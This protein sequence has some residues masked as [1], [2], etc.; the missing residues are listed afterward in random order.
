[1]PR[2]NQ[3]PCGYCDGLGLHRWYCRHTVIAYLA[4]LSGGLLVL[5][6]GIATGARQ[7]SYPGLAVW[8]LVLDV[9]IALALLRGRRE[10]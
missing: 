6:A 4:L 2:A 7:L 10:R 8:F 3:E 1:M 9:L 5:I